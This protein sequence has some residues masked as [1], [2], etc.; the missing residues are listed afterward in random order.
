MFNNEEERL[1]TFERGKDHSVQ[2][3]LWVCICG[4]NVQQGKK[5]TKLRCP[6][7]DL[8]MQWKPI[9]SVA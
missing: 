5:R 4:Y 2:W 8:W 6:K 3:A 1:K 9:I 7:C